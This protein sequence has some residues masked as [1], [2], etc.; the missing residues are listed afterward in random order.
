MDSNVFLMLIRLD[1][2]KQNPTRIGEFAA[3]DEERGSQ[4]LVGVLDPQ[5]RTA[6]TPL[7]AI[8]FKE[9][10]CKT[11]NRA[12][13]RIQEISDMFYN[14]GFLQDPSSYDQFSQNL[15]FDKMSTLG[16]LIY[17][18]FSDKKTMPVR[19]WLD[20]LFGRVSKGKSRN[21]QTNVTIITNDF[22][23]PWFWMKNEPFGPSLCEVCSLGMIQLQNTGFN[24]DPEEGGCVKDRALLVRGT[25]EQPFLE[26][27]LEIVDRTLSTR[28]HRELIENFDVHRV[29]TVEELERISGDMSIDRKKEF[30]IV[31]FAGRYALD[32]LTVGSRNV[33]F[34]KWEAYLKNSILVL[35]GMSESEGIEAWK[36]LEKVTAKYIEKGEALACILP[37]LP[38]KDDPIAAE[39]FWGAF[40]KEI[41]RGSATIG[42]ALNKARIILKNHFRDA[43][44][45]NY[46]WAMYQLIGSPSTR[47]RDQGPQTDD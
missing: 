42:Q 38:I 14:N 24:P 31:H 22:S 20:D 7:T 34:K 40:Y 19:N 18:F 46:S 45:S 28:G 2:N 11:Y 16:L 21:R 23:I 9:N 15:L 43:G 26:E 3:M 32:S 36:D 37:V 13:T 30:K 29:E 33:D 25:K 6:S 27:A 41:K 44:I 47:L 12:L 1:L 17:S 10:K 5:R 39:F 35:D 4:F 8:E